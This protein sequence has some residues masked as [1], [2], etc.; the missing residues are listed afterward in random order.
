VLRLFI[1]L[2][3]LILNLLA[4]KGGYASCKKKIIDSNA[5]LSKTLQ[6]PVQKHKRLVFSETT[7]HNYKIY[8]SDPYLGLYLVED[9]KGFRYP[10]RLNMRYPSGLAVI[11]RTSAQEGRIV[12]NQIGL[13]HF[14]Q[15]NGAVFAPALLLNSCCSL[16]GI[17]TPRGIIQK[18]YIDR[19][20]KVKKVTYSDIGIR[21]KNN[22]GVVVTAR[23]P[24]MKNNPFQVGDCILYM[25]G[26]KVRRASKLMRDILFSKIGSKHKVKIKRGSKILTITVRSQNRQSGGYKSDTFL[27]QYGLHFDKDLR[28]IKIEKK[29]E[30]YQLLVGDKLLQV[31]GV[32]VTNQQEVM[33][34][35]SNFKDYASLLFE[36]RNFQ[37]FVNV[38]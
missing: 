2:N 34:N 11:N 36:R 32:K 17:V 37:F 22:K 24:F 3:L 30:K 4:C 12:K 27:E 33:D 23:D 19:F 38:N 14:A 28:V 29:A 1:I 13:N 7:P 35:I 31:N 8:K 5:V 25:D 6:I 26:R 18:E 21:V 9:K 15:F 10:F 20:L 16:E